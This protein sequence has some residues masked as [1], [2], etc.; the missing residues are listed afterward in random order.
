[1]KYLGKIEIKEGFSL[2]N[3]T[4][5]VRGIF[6][7]INEEG[8][9]DFKYIEIHFTEPNQKLIHSRFWIV[10]DETIEEFLTSHNVLYKFK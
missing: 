7:S 8:E 5:E 4:M 3:P 2:F 9:V 1:M 10:T 6:E